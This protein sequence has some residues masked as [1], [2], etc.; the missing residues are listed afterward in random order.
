ML[1]SACT[2]LDL[3]LVLSQ[4]LAQGMTA[5]VPLSRYAVPE[6]YNVAARHLQLMR[7]IP[8]KSVLS[9]VVGM[10]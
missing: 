2:D 3:N 6:I 1:V 8:S 4:P 7:S 9:C 5:T 10:K